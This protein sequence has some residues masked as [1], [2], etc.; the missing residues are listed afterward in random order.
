MKLQNMHWN[1]IWIHKNVPSSGHWQNN[2][3]FM[4][5][6]RGINLSSDP[7][8]PS[9]LHPGSFYS[10]V[11]KGSSWVFKLFALLTI[12]SNYVSMFFFQRFLLVRWSSM[13]KI[14]A[15]LRYVTLRIIKMIH[16]MY[17]DFESLNLFLNNLKCYV[18]T[19]NQ[20]VYPHKKSSNL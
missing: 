7:K 4:G 18:S 14:H 3:W 9:G 17:Y 13:L 19:I 10:H 11:S 1:I 5:R 16:H 12:D 15:I 8:S 6:W 2:T 20:L